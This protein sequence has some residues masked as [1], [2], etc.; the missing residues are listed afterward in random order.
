[1]LTYPGDPIISKAIADVLLKISD[2]DLLARLVGTVTKQFK[3]FTGIVQINSG[4]VT[5]RLRPVGYFEKLYLH[6]P[7]A[8]AVT[9][10]EE[11]R[12]GEVY[13]TL[14][15]NTDFEVESDERYSAL[16]PITAGGFYPG[17]GDR[18][19]KVVY[20]GGWSDTPEDVLLGAEM[21]IRLQAKRQKGDIGAAN[22]SRGG[23]ADGGRTAEAIPQEV[24]ELWLPYR[25]M[26]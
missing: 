9:T 11:Y 14:T 17:G 16:V 15:E 12:A 24:R 5:E 20:T 10:F 7:N 23:Q 4:E 26:V 25:V 13:R 19:T 8:S 21:L 3:A 2:D 22:R 6:A 18:F 1:M